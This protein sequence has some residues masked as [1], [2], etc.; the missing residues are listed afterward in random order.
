MNIGV[1]IIKSA[2][3]IGLKGQ[4]L[5]MIKKSKEKLLFSKEE[6]KKIEKEF[7]DNCN[8]FNID[9]ATCLINSLE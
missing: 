2:S 5:M 1:V 3:F 7:I 6:T 4:Y 9:V 8:E